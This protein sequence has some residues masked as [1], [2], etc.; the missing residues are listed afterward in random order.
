MGKFFSMVL[1]VLLLG[2]FGFSEEIFKDIIPGRIFVIDRQGN[3]YTDANFYSIAKYS[4]E[5]KFL[6][7]IGAKGEGP[8]CFKRIGWF[9]INPVEPVIYVTEILGNKWISKFSTD[10]KYLGE[11]KCDLDFKKYD[12]F[13]FINFDKK[14]NVY[15]HTVKTYFTHYKDFTIIKE[16]NSI[17]KFSSTGKK[18]KE[19]YKFSA[20]MSMQKP[21][22]GNVNIPF[23]NTFYWT[24]YENNVIVIERNSNLISILSE[25]GKLERKISLPYKREKITEKDIDAWEDWMKGFREIRNNISA[26]WFSLKYWRSNLPFP[27]YKPVIGD[28]RVDSYGNIYTSKYSGYSKSNNEA[29]SWIRTDWSSGK[30]TIVTFPQNS[31]PLI[32]WKNFFF[33]ASEDEDGETI[34][35]KIDEKE[36]F[37]KNEEIK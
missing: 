15:L 35:K 18:I 26:G 3:F 28:L 37:K 7:K 22:K 4:P 16:E 11:W 13:L 21:E 36:L 9:N 33:F 34:I 20:D 30:N 10:G 32:I 1:I 24:V 8:S 19:I 27:E 6:M 23:E 14:G 12:G 17:L 31:Y 25:D 2:A 29:K 5:G